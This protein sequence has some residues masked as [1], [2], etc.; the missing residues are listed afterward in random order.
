M[1]K[2]LFILIVFLIASCGT[3]KH[4][5]T[6]YQRDTVYIHNT[7]YLKDSIFVYKDRNIYTKGDTVFVTL[8][9]YETKWKLKEVHDTLYKEKVKIETNT[10]YIEKQ[11]TSWQK[12]IQYLGYICMGLFLGLFGYGVYKLIKTLRK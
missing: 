12:F 4:I 3:G 1:R 8:K 6:I 7:K 9:E 10:E 11:F 5:P 2:L